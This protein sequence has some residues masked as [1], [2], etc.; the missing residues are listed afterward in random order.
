VT[1]RAE[2]TEKRYSM[3]D[4]LRMMLDVRAEAICAE[5][6]SP[7]DPKIFSAGS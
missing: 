3:T 7:V 4:E 6:I 1:A 2:A 5:P